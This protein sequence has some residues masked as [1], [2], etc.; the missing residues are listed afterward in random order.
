MME[1]LISEYRAS[2]AFRDQRAD[3]ATADATN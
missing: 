1:R 3:E 2:R